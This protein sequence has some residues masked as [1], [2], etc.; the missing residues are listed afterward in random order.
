MRWRCRRHSAPAIRSP[1]PS[2]RRRKATSSPQTS[3]RP[4]RRPLC[5]C[6]TSASPLDEEALSDLLWK[7]EGALFALGARV[8]GLPRRR[9]CSMQ[10]ASPQAR[11]TA[12]CA[13]CLACRERWRPGRIPLAKVS[14]GGCR[15]DRGGPAL[16]VTADAR[17]EALLGDCS[18]QIRRNLDVARQFTATLPRA[19]RVAFLPLALVEPYLRVL[20]RSGGALLREEARRCAAH[21]GLQDCR[22]PSVRPAVTAGDARCAPWRAREGDCDAGD[23]GL[24]ARCWR[25]S[26]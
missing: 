7:T 12:W 15:L 2:A 26:S 22:R 19:A 11:R 21:A 13:C 18:A 5:S 24:A 6:S 10:A 9:R 17:I 23:G 14:A 8:V 20:E 4:D 25:G 1:T 16:G 3:W